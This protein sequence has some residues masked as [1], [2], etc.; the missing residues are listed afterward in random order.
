MSCSKAAQDL[1][2]SPAKRLRTSQFARPLGHRL[3]SEEVRTLLK[4]RRR[5][6]GS[7]DY[8]AAGLGLKAGPST[9]EDFSAWPTIMVKDFLSMPNGSARLSRVAAFVEKGLIVHSDCSG[10]CTPEAALE[11][12]DVALQQNGIVLP[13]E[14]M[15]PWRTCDA[16]DL[17][18]EVESKL[19]RRP[20]R[21][22]KGVLEKLPE[23]HAD[24]IRR[25]R[26]QA[27]ASKEER[28][29]AYQSMDDY[30]A[31]H[32]KTLYPKGATA[33]N[34]ILHPGKECKLRW[35]DP[36]HLSSAERPITFG[37]FGP[38]C[39]PFTLYGNRLGR[40]HED[41][42]TIHVCRHDINASKLDVV[43]FENS[44]H[45]EQS[46]FMLPEEDYD[47][48]FAIFGSQ[49][50][51]W[52]VRRARF[53]SWSILRDHLVW[54]GPS[55]KDVLIDFLTFFGA[56]CVSDVDVFV[57]LEGEDANV[58]AL[59]R[60]AR[61]RGS[62][63]S[64]EQAKACHWSTFLA[65]CASAALAQ[66][67][68]MY[69]AGNKIGHAGAMACDLSQSPQRAR[70][71]AFMPAF[72]RSSL[73]CSISS[74]HLF[75]A[76][77]VDF[78]MGW[79]AIDNDHNEAFASRLGLQK[80]YQDIGRHGRNHLSGNGMMLPQLLAW[81]LYCMSNTV[82]RSSL[83]GFQWPLSSTC[84]GTEVDSETQGGQAMT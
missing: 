34:C 72:A 31:R 9:L 49:D 74:N 5:P 45:C 28:V 3:S 20:C 60:L 19:I 69:A 1:P 68:E 59:M 30:L 78:A 10:K 61:N 14:W 16:S 65:P 48:H 33:R 77:E 82:R 23:V 64:E 39:R 7:S 13:E 2:A 35:T 83:E 32:S 53:Y 37:V 18:L 73:M 51:G 81:K 29:D 75:T 22:F 42:E 46:L 47:N 63:L 44:D 84:T 76:G 79:P 11:M 26:P 80:V 25:M 55:S 52:P 17:C 8:H 36:P 12:M 24:A 67:R 43:M 40:A 50:Q 57:G 21:M 66:A 54:I 15:I 58:E 27:N 6:G 41:M 62:Y 70:M 56:L 4:L 71:G 38:P